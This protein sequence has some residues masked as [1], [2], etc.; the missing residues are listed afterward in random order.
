MAANLSLLLPR[1]LQRPDDLPAF[2]DLAYD[3]VETLASLELE[4]VPT[5]RA[6]FQHY[7]LLR[8]M[9][10]GV[11]VWLR[12][13]NR[14]LFIWEPQV[15]QDHRDL[16][17][18]LLDLIAATQGNVSNPPPDIAAFMQER[19]FTK[20]IYTVTQSIGCILD[21]GVEA[22]ASRKNFGNRFEELVQA[23]LDYLGVA[24]SALNIVLRP[25][26]L[27]YQAALDRVVSLGTELHSTVA[28]LDERDVILSVKTSSK[29]RMKLIFLDRFLIE[30]ATSRDRVPFVA[31]YHNDVQRARGEVA[32]TF[33]PDIFLICCHFLGELSGVYYVD[34]PAVL[35]QA[36]FTGLLHYF[37]DFFLGDLWRLL[38]G[39][40]PEAPPV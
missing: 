9:R 7:S 36:R 38:E 13:I 12:P 11:G 18:R 23:L 33:V 25:M 22:Q 8:Q 24:N 40:A 30:K 3:C 19:G 6:N 4:Q 34:P 16:S 35:G 26:G 17:L 27:R 15:L 31:L 1:V 29:D 21:L 28:H 5:N 10:S 14:N 20:A 37:E 39:R 32:Q 2:Y